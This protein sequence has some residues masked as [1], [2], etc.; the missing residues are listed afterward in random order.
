MLK[1]PL[2][3]RGKLGRTRPGFSIPCPGLP[4]PKAPPVGGPGPP[5]LRLQ[6]SPSGAP[7]FPHPLPPAG[8]GLFTAY[9]ASQ[10]SPPPQVPQAPQ[11][12]RTKPETHPSTATRPQEE[13]LSEASGLSSARQGVGSGTD[14]RR[15][16]LEGVVPSEM[17]LSLKDTCCLIP[18]TEVPRAV[19]SRGTE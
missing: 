10:M 13:T 3:K 1:T 6:A 15:L 7:A 8:W 19:G 9:P 16:Y 2:T 17:S 4:S 18:L 11:L 5:H 14:Q 12:H